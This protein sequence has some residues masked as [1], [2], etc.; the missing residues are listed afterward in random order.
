MHVQELVRFFLIT[1]VEAIAIVVGYL[2]IIEEEMM[3]M[4]MMMNHGAKQLVV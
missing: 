4:M 3:M 2:Q 1:K